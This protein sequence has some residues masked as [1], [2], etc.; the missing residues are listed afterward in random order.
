MFAASLFVCTFLLS[1][2]GAGAPPAEPPPA[3]T[4]ASEA[5]PP[6]EADASAPPTR[7]RLA[8]ADTQINTDELD[9]LI[10][11]SL[12]SV[13]TAEVELR[14]SD[15]YTV[16]SRNETRSLLQRV[17]DRQAIASSDE[18]S[19][20]IFE[21]LSAQRIVTSSV[22]RVGDEWVLTLELLDDQTAKVVARQSVSF[23]GAP[24]GLLELVRPYVTR[25][26]EGSRA[27]GYQGNLEILLDEPEAQVTVDAKEVGLSPV[28]PIPDLPIGRH[29]VSIFKD[30]F[31]PY[32][33]DVVVQRNETTLLQVSLIDESTL[34][35]WWQKWWVWTA[36]GSGIV[37]GTVLTVVL[38]NDDDS[39]RLVIDQP[40]ETSGLGVRW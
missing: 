4:R 36:V 1:A 23:K 11:Q 35:P 10:G 33:G 25:L 30:G 16:I 20:R 28:A 22:A 7:P 6:E 24:E 32:E 26:L 12:S 34:T 15:A 14:A 27:E 29:R 39:G 18:F 17:A 38:L 40:F 31:V 2:A 9:P 19:D 5:T 8:V 13:I 3:N 21:L 37:L